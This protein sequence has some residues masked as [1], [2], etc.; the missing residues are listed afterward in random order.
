LKYSSVKGIMMSYKLT[1]GE[2]AESWCSQKKF[3]YLI[4]VI[5]FD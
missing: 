3:S 5:T 2:F 1:Y 4:W